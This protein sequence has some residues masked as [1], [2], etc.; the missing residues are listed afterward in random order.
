MAA[1][2]I[3]LCGC[4]EMQKGNDEST[5]YSGRMVQTTDIGEAVKQEPDE[6]IRL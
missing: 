2:S 4:K 1:A 5:L 3:I 6:V